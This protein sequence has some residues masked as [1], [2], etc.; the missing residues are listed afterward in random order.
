MSTGGQKLHR[1]LD[2]LICL[3]LPLRREELKAKQKHW[4]PIGGAQ[5]AE[6]AL[7]EAFLKF[8]PLDRICF[9]PTGAE[10]G[11]ELNE[12]LAEYPYSNGS[13]VFS[14]T[15]ALRHQG[16]TLIF[17]GS[18]RLF[19]AAGFRSFWGSADW[20]M[21]GITHALSGSDGI[22]SAMF[23]ATPS[24]HLKSFD[25]LICT[26]N[27]ADLAFQELEA[28]VRQPQ[29]DD[30]STADKYGIQKSVIPLGVD[31]ERFAPGPAAG[32]RAKLGLTSD[33]VVFLYCGRFSVEFKMDP[34]PL[35]AAFALAFGGQSNV[36]LILAGDSTG[37]GHIKIPNM[38]RDLQIGNQVSIVTDPSAVVKLGL[39]QAADVFVSFSDNL[40]E[41][42]GIT[43]LEAMSCGLPVLAT[44]WSGYRDTVVHEETGFL[45]PTTWY[46]TDSYASRLS[47]FYSEQSVHR[48]F[49]QEISFD[50]RAAAAAMQRLALNRELRNELGRRGRLRAV[51]HYAWSMIADRYGRLFRELLAEAADSGRRGV[52]TPAT[53]P[54]YSYDH[55]PVFQHFATNVSGPPTAVAWVADDRVFPA[56]S[57]L[58]PQAAL[59]ALADTRERGSVLPTAQ[60]VGV[61]TAALGESHAAISVLQLL[62]KYGVLAVA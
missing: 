56:V 8:R 31:V 17:Q 54:P 48:M 51:R 44:D 61:L 1:G 50:M 6:C 29:M 9:V 55:L 60:L 58:L 62:L 35:L 5:V 49:S 23:T 43:I 28:R 39:Y 27:A 34:F 36:K 20:P 3:G 53:Y 2:R 32:V 38:A 16:R 10:S 12:R 42:F 33:D 13:T 22:A 57:K 41:T 25:R 26:S 21:V 19:E 47:P 7:V 37:G 15:E 30:D 18:P 45:M 40:Q 11:A 46:A 59:A 14:P 24:E 4:M 52:P